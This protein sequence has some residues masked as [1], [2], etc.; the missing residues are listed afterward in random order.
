MPQ[1]NVESRLEKAYVEAKSLDIDLN[2]ARIIVFSDQHKG[3]GDG[4]DDFR[5]CKRAYHA[6]LGYYL[7]KGHSLFILGD[8]EELWECKAQDV[9]ARYGDTLELERKFASEGN[10]Y[11]RFFGNHD[12]KW[13]K[14]VEVMK[15]LKPI[16]GDGLEV[17]EGLK[18]RVLKKGKPLGTL[19]FVHG[20]QGD[21]ASDDFAS[22]S[23]YV[24]RYAWGTW[25]RLTGTKSATPAT[26]FNLRKE[27]ELAMYE[28]ARTKKDV[29]MIAGHTHHPVFE[30]TS[31]SATRS[32]E[33]QELKAGLKGLKGAKLAQQQEKIALASAKLNWAQ[34]QHPDSFAEIENIKP[35]YF[36]S[37][38]CCFSDGDITGI[39]ICDGSIQLVRWP[40]D[41]GDPA[42]KEFENARANLEEVF[43]ACAK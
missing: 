16:L 25:Q 18:L 15:F 41:N 4:A 5:D 33:L 21:P 31:L 7:E 26:D 23:K 11:V 13:S 32:K 3:K 34:A 9:I 8:A 39:E 38:C 28:W 6:A 19:F 17:V 10:R 20:H 36:N 22:F 24:V 30:S 12:L 29:V 37:G 35:C 14:D 1:A 43:A 2:T 42:P 27:H 40:D